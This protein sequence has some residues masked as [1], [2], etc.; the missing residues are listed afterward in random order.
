MLHSLHFETP[1]LTNAWA[2]LSI[3]LLVITFFPTLFDVMVMGD[4][5]F[6]RAGNAKLLSAN[7][8]PAL[9]SRCCDVAAVR[10]AAATALDASGNRAVNSLASSGRRIADACEFGWFMCRLDSVD[11]DIVRTLRGL[12]D[13]RGLCRFGDGVVDGLPGNDGAHTICSGDADVLLFS[14]KFS[15]PSCRLSALWRC[16]SPE[17][18]DEIDAERSRN[19]RST[20][21]RRTDKSNGVVLP[22]LIRKKK[23][24]VSFK[25]CTCRR[26]LLR[27]FA[28]MQVNLSLPVMRLFALYRFWWFGNIR[29]AFRVIWL[30]QRFGDWCLSSCW[31]SRCI[32]STLHWDCLSYWL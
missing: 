10:T 26:F 32:T 13:A 9:S 14:S 5:D 18:E 16:K 1:C 7:S 27:T 31:F 30:R 15:L 2:R 11:G 22:S 19:G 28:E 24:I 3:E 17:I 29:T 21:D 12:I 4:V 8:K 23:T 20:D 6:A 25:I